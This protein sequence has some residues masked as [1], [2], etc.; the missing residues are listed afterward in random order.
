MAED[1]KPAKKKKAEDKGSAITRLR[2][3]LA[4]SYNGIF[5][6]VIQPQLPKSRVMGFMLMSFVIGMIWAYMV[7]P[8]SFYDAAPS[9]L[10]SS[11]RDQYV[12]FIAVSFA[13]G[14]YGEQDTIR[15]LNR[16]ENPAA[17]VQRLIQNEVGVVRSSLEQVLPLAQ[18]AGGTSAPSSGSI[19]GSIIGIILAIIVFVLVVNVFALLWGLIIGGYWERLINRFRPETEADR[20]A[21][22]AIEAIKQ[23]KALEVQMKEEAKL[24]TAGG[25]SFGPPIMQRISPYQ[26]G[27]AFDDSFAIEDENDAFL[28]ECGATIGKTLGPENDLAAIEIWLFDKE[29]FVRTLTKLFVSEHLYNDPTARAELEQKVDNPST[30]LVVAQPGA[31]ILLDTDAIRVQA[32][33]AELTYGS[34][35]GLP[36][37]SHFEAMTLRMEAWKKEGASA[38]I[39]SP[40]VPAAVGGLPPV[41]SYEI[42]PP[43]PMPGGAPASMPPPQQPTRPAAPL[44]GGG[45]FGGEMRPPQQP[46]PSGGGIRPLSPPVQPPPQRQDDDDPFGG[47]GDFTPIGG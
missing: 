38:P 11:H 27:R 22:L 8:T 31:T 29:D 30:D 26:K 20:K 37:N 36:P 39:V 44:G 46:P 43:P 42:G 9:Q 7:A 1:P 13:E 21:K 28:G 4:D 35:A 5:K 32:K 34:T 6:I 24:E 12:K 19:I 2:A 10:S 33:I 47:T 14:A 3:W 16:V 45:N 41:D 18:Q 17:T 40:P 23:R 25:S 15:F